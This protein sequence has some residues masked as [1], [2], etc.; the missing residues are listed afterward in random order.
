[1]S[2]YLVMTRICP[3]CNFENQDDYDFCAKCG[4]P[5]IEGVQPKNIIV[6]NAQPRLNKKVLLISYIVT[7][8]LSWG[9]FIFNFI[10]KNTHFAFFTFFG[11]FLPFYLIQAPV[12]E[13][14]KH[15]LIMLIISVVGVG[16]SFYVMF[17]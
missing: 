8:F 10:S 12:K 1:M 16:L 3:K 9:G 7:I 14:R 15:G 17:K 2:N 5:L 11:F 4:T 6:Y 13:L